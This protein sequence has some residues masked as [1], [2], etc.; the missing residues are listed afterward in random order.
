MNVLVLKELIQHIQF[1]KC[2]ISNQRL[3]NKPLMVVLVLGGW[4]IWFQSTSFKYLFK[5]RELK[6]LFEI[7]D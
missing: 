5:P 2:K 7:E 1:F 6:L 3:K 4:N